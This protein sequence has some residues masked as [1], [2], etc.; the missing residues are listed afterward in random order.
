MEDYLSHHGILG[1]KW[2]V[3]RYQNKDGSLTAAG[4]KRISQG[5]S[6]LTQKEQDQI[7]KAFLGPRN[8]TDAQRRAI[9]VIRK[10]PEYK[11]SVEDLANDPNFRNDCIRE[12]IWK[13]YYESS[14]PK[15]LPDSVQKI[16][17]EMIKVAREETIEA[18]VSEYG[19]SKSEASKYKDEDSLYALGLSPTLD[20]IP[21][22]VWPAL[23]KLYPVSN[24]P[25]TTTSKLADDLVSNLTG[26]KS[27]EDLGSVGGSLW[28]SINGDATE[29]LF[30]ERY[31]VPGHYGKLYNSK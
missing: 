5:A 3:R 21:D 6:S 26:I 27:S 14:N 7:R 29:K 8:N 28:S 10:T 17:D 1:Q 4:K 20:L 30:Q 2:G 22:R 11:K 24:N 15:P 25:G 18:L 16:N 9:E 31:G 19:M 13:D 12:W 23:C